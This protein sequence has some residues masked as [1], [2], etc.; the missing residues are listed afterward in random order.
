[1]GAVSYFSVEVLSPFLGDGIRWAMESPR[2][3]GFCNVCFE[4]DCLQLFQ[5]W[6]ARFIGELSYLF[7]VIGVCW[8]ATSFFVFSS[9]FVCGIGNSVVDFMAS[10]SSPTVMLYG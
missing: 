3:L 4:T 2:D 9:S 8:L 1:M 6:Q 7:F 10:M 5:S